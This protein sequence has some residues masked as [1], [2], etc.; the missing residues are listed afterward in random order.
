MATIEL[1]SIPGILKSL[2]CLENL[3]YKSSSSNRLFNCKCKKCKQWNTLRN[4]YRKNINSSYRE[5]QLS[6]TKKWKSNNLD[7]GRRS[8]A[9]RRATYSEKYTELDVLVKYGTDCH[10]CAKSI[11]MDLNRSPGKPG[12]EMSLHIDHLV[13]I[14]KGGP[15][16]LDNVRPSHGL[17]NI[18]KGSKLEI[19]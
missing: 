1:D 10:I 17:C 15:D 19:K 9:R 8:E 12:W 14:S 4:F 18:K 13:P 2:Y 16:T 7:S 3:G 11:D 5:K 6:A